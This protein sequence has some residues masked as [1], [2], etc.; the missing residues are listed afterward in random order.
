LNQ[1]KS[2]QALARPFVSGRAGAGKAWSIEIQ[3][4]H[5]R[6]TYFSNVHNK[7]I[8]IFMAYSGITILHGTREVKTPQHIRL[9]KHTPA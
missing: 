7:S 3:K 4:H 1:C 8:T 5:R 2:G 6:I 9:V